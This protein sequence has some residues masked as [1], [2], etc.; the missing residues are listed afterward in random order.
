MQAQVITLHFYVA[1]DSFYD[2]FLQ[3]FLKNKKICSIYDYFFAKDQNLC[4]YV[5]VAYTLPHP[6][7]ISSATKAEM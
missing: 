2:T 5:V 4:F 3:V 7:I 6:V 1:M